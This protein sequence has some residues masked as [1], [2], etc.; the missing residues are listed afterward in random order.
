MFQ[1]YWVLSQ[2]YL[3]RLID[4]MSE[5]LNNFDFSDENKQI[6]VDILKKYPVDRKNSAVMP[7]L[8]IAQRQNDGWLSRDTIEYVAEYL[9]MPII[10][11]MEVV[12]FYTMYHTKPVGKN[13]VQVC[14]TT[15]CWLRGSDNIVKAC[16]EM[17]SPE[18]KT[19]S[20]DGLFSWMQVECLGACV[21]APVVQINDD[22]YEDLTYDTTKN[23][24]QSLIDN[25]PLQVGSQSGRK[26]S[27]AD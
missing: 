14:T 27:R 5:N 3:E 10:K 13:L 9:D 22:Y 20:N 2:L 11:V 6:A 19:V 21:N 23:I 16:K 15:P 1:R 26:G 17:I 8:D 12:T 18:Q 4:S 24:L 7:L 25:K